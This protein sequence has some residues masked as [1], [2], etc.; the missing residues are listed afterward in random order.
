[1]YLPTPDGISLKTV[2]SQSTAGRAGQVC[3]YIGR[4]VWGTLSFAASETARKMRHT[5]VIKE[6]I[7]RGVCG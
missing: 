5:V 4:Y 3:R 2:S 1:M 7:K 6:A